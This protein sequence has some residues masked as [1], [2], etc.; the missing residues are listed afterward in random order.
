MPLGISLI[1]LFHFI[2]FKS[3]QSLYLALFLLIF[4]SNGIFSGFLWKIVEKPWQRLSPKEVSKS[5][6]IVVLSGGGRRL[7]P[8]NSD[9]IE[10]NDPDRFLA[11]LLLLKNEK[12]SKLIFTGGINPYKKGLPPEGNLYKI[13][14]I[15]LGL[16]KEQ[17]Y[18][19]DPASNTLQEVKQIKKVLKELLNDENPKILLVTSAYHMK[20]AKNLFN[21]Y[22]INVQ[23]FPVDFR[24]DEIN[25]NYIK[26]PL[27]WIPNSQNL[28]SS[29]SALREILG[30]FI[31]KYL[32]FYPSDT[33]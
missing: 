5:D 26:N 25:L 14:A 12:S 3:K 1:S 22:E 7:T 18:V 28:S 2:F 8:R 11:G 15:K 32:Y 10:W 4:F 31:Y 6:A 29:S 21:K 24:S 9:I 23:P 16:P 33:D 17:I 27:N 13:E 19:T 20:R 30:R